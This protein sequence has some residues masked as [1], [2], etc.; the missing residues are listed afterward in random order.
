M[1]V[2]WFSLRYFVCPCRSVASFCDEIF[3]MSFGCITQST[4]IPGGGTPIP[5]NSNSTTIDQQNCVIS[6]NYDE[7]GNRS[8]IDYAAITI[9][10]EFTW[11][12]TFS[13]NRTSFSIHFPKGNHNLRP[14]RMAV[15]SAWNPVFLF[16]SGIIEFKWW[17]HECCWRF[18]KIK[19]E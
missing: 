3:W 11:I 4:P 6:F 19:P 5:G 7:S 9:H 10:I 18:S 15:I 14:T 1:E 17:W 13:S 2:L 16:I 12:F 8:H